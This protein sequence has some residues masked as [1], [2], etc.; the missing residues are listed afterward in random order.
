[1]T[2]LLDLPDELLLE[3]IKQTCPEGIENL[4]SCCKK[5]YNTS[6]RILEKHRTNKRKYSRLAWPPA[7]LWQPDDEG[8]GFATSLSKLLYE[9]Q[10]A[11]YVRSLQYYTHRGEDREQLLKIFPQKSI[12]TGDGVWQDFFDV[13]ECPF[14]PEAELADWQKKID[15]ADMETVLALLLTKLPNLERLAVR[16]LQSGIEVLT[17]MKHSSKAHQSPN[18]HIRMHAPL[19]KLKVI[20]ELD[21][22]PE[23]SNIGLLEAFFMLPSMKA[24]QYRGEIDVF[25]LWPSSP[26]ISEMTRVNYREPKHHGHSVMNINLEA[27]DR[28]L[29]HVRHLEHFDHKRD[30]DNH[31]QETKTTDIVKVVD[32][33]A[34]AT[35][36]KLNLHFYHVS[37]LQMK[38]NNIFVGSLRS[39]T[40]LSKI[41]IS[42]ALLIRNQNDQCT[43]ARL[44]DIMPSSLEELIIGDHY[45]FGR[46]VPNEDETRL[47][48]HTVENESGVLDHPRNLE[49][50]PDLQEKDDFLE[51]TVE[52]LTGVFDGFPELKEKRLP[53]LKLVVLAE[54]VARTVLLVHKKMNIMCEKEGIAL[55][56]RSFQDN[57]RLSDRIEKCSR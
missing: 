45:I 33:H 37:L 44:V 9:P 55:E 8:W 23:A 22:T 16:S 56:P 43:A 49:N 14:I 20:S 11:P 39:F 4:V 12:E 51:R 35:L 42:L 25:N 5:L 46:P 50:E 29:A 52:F 40:H 7:D 21:I 2:Q 26:A 18:A 32:K 6:D 3:I 24:I 10:L 28:V 13:S 1:M 36:T 15:M 27:F 57:Y 54:F 31:F 41:D 48:H 53:N 17:M 47:D 38:K 30:C 34:R 19:R